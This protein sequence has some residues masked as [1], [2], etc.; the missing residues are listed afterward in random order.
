MQHNKK[1]R[2][3]KASS[4]RRRAVAKAD[5]TEADG[6]AIANLVEVVTKYEGAVRFG[7]S[8]DGGAYAVGLYDGGD[9]WTEYLGGNEDVSEWIQELADRFSGGVN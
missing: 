8:R 7:L 5:W 1:E 9:S 3:R 6:S 2:S 4:S